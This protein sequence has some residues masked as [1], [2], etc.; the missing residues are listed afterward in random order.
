MLKLFAATIFL[1][2]FCVV[3]PGYAEAT[4]SH[5]VN[6]LGAGIKVLKQLQNL[7][8][9]Y[10]FLDA[11]QPNSIA[12]ELLE[13]FRANKVR[14]S[15]IKT[16]DL[17]LNVVSDT[18][19][20][21]NFKNPVSKKNET[22]LLNEKTHSFTYKYNDKN[23]EYTW[24]AKKTATQNMIQW[25]QQFKSLLKESK[26]T[27][28]KAV[29]QV[30]KILIP[31]AQAS[32]PD[33]EPEELGREYQYEVMAGF[34]SVMSL[35]TA[36]YAFVVTTT[37]AGFLA[38]ILGLSV[39]PAA[40]MA[41]VI[42]LIFEYQRDRGHIDHPRA[43]QLVCKPTIRALGRRMDTFNPEQVKIF[44]AYCQDRKKRDLFNEA[45]RSVREKILSGELKIESTLAIVESSGK[46]IDT[47]AT[48]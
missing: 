18:T 20:K 29:S 33:S 15:E 44:E 2:N 43:L 24:G 38:A 37:T 1:I 26:P 41:L 8:Q 48:K 45:T 10:V 7:E 13:Y 39:A 9:F 3:H 25:D 4:R 36:A 27:K 16:K 23:T 12:H 11:I 34:A 30:L 47:K 40:V 22:I 31:T 28:S 21:L 17:N 19:I 5:A 14:L 46:P 6:E 32:D 42:F 35:V